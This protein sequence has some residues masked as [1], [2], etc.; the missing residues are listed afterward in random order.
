MLCYSRLLRQAL[1][2]REPRHPHRGCSNQQTALVGKTWGWGEGRYSTPQ[3]SGEE[4]ELVQGIAPQPRR[5]GPQAGVA[6][7][8][9]GTPNITSP[10]SQPHWV[11]KTTANPFGTPEEPPKQQARVRNLL[12]GDESRVTPSCFQNSP[13]FQPPDSLPWPSLQGSR[14]VEGSSETLLQLGTTRATCVAKI[15]T[16]ALIPG[17]FW[18]LT[19]GSSS[20]PALSTPMVGP[21]G[22][23]VCVCVCVCVQL[24]EEMW[25][26]PWGPSLIFQG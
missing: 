18:S 22:V 5:G 12:L 6:S 20:R 4:A 19:Q 11:L 2:L 1:C 24:W 9:R 13:T 17:Y 23:C 8:A 15:L 14:E 25:L 26:P 21:W 16:R 3:P 7:V 10:T